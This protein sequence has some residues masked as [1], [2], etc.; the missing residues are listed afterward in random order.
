[1]SKNVYMKLNV[2]FITPINVPVS[3]RTITGSVYTEIILKKGI[4]LK[5]ILKN[6]ENFK[7]AK[8]GKH[9]V[10]A[11]RKFKWHCY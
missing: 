10:K 5:Q 8:N 1:M 6:G 3:M 2:C 4:I 9:F 11:N 7:F